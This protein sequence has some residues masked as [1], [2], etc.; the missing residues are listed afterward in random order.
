VRTS[1]EGSGFFILKIYYV[2]QVVI[3]N[4]TEFIDT[5]NS[6][7]GFYIPA[8]SQIADLFLQVSEEM[9]NE[10]T[11]PLTVCV[12]YKDFGFSLFDLVSINYSKEALGYDSEF[13]VVY[14]Y[15]STAS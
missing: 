6:K 2:M 8:E 9:N 4:L 1:I 10:H 15:Q 7:G 5:H 14:K 11:T 13:I 12:S 3:E